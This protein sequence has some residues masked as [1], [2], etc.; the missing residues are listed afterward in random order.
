MISNT[1]LIEKNCLYKIADVRSQYACLY[2]YTIYY[3]YV[4]AVHRFY[5]TA[6]NLSYI[7]I[8]SNITFFYNVDGFK[9]LI[10]YAKCP[11]RNLI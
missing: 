3:R 2:K 9:G 7:I 11:L 5:T 1:C 4:P 6:Q 10:D 8:Q